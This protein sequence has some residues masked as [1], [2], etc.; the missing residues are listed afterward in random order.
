MPYLVLVRHG[1]SR[2]NKANKFTGWVDVPL[3]EVGIHEAMITAER[4]KGLRFDVAFSSRL[5]RAEQTLLLILAEQ[6]KTGVF[7]HE[8]SLRKR[9][10]KHSHGVEYTDDEL[11]VFCSDKLNERY[12]GQLQGMDK[13]DARKQYGEHQVFIWRRSYRGRPPRGESLE[14]VCKRVLPYFKRRIIPELQ[15]GRNVLVSAH[16]NSL[17]GV[18]KYLDGISDDDI[19]TL[20]LPYAKPIIYEHKDGRLVKVDHEHSFD[21]PLHWQHTESHHD[22]HDHK[23][24]SSKKKPSKQ[25]S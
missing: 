5:V 8:S 14:D 25:Q 17:R 16:G 20:E 1:E 24:T 21:R 13:D 9:W 7:L 12:Y 11:P 2:W 18:I 10:S 6:E 3:S 19:P 23:R 4:L 22:Y 15:K